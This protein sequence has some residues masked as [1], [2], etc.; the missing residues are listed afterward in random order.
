MLCTC[1]TEHNAV[2]MEHLHIKKKMVY[3]IMKVL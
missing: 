2:I 3:E 1:V